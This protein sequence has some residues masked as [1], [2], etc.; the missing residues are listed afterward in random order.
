MKFGS[1]LALR[2][3]VTPAAGVTIS[4]VEVDGQIVSPIKSGDD[5]IVTISGIKATELINIHTIVAEGATTTVSPMSYVYSALSTNGVR[6]EI[7]DLVCALYN[8][9]QACK[10]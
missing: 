5:Y 10:E 4:N 6:D 3:T 7:K 9:A 8:Y 1:E 2:I